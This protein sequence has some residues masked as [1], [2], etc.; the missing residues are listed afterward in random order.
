VKKE[1]RVVVLPLDDDS[2][3]IQI[4]WSAGGAVNLKE[5]H[6]DVQKVLRLA[7]DYYMGNHMMENFYPDVHERANFA[8]ESF[9]SAAEDLHF[10]NIA[11]A[12]VVE[13]SGGRAL[14]K[15]GEALAV[16]VSDLPLCSD[17]C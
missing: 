2:D 10:P 9:V 13:V 17:I 7:I 12:V 15:Y 11:S 14:S 4:R 6:P 8:V 3:N 1:A 16:V 5:Q